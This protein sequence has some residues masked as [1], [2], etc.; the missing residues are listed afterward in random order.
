MMT[1]VA[2]IPGVRY[3]LKVA[4]VFS[5]WIAA[6]YCYGLPSYH[7]VV[8]LLAG[9]FLRCFVGR[10]PAVFTYFSGLT[11]ANTPKTGTVA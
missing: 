6:D 10:H 8:D 5:F 4:V 2:I 7:Y 3:R 9:R 1:I 11:P